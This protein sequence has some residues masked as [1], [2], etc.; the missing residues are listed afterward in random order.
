MYLLFVYNVSDSILVT[1]DTNNK[2]K[3]CPPDCQNLEK[4]N[5]CSNK[6]KK[7]F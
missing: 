5:N 3:S 7:A 2:T 1:S 4:D 6:N